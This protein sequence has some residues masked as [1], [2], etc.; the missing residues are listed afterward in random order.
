MVAPVH[1]ITSSEFRRAK[2]VT[3]AD[4]SR[5]LAEQQMVVYGYGQPGVPTGVWSEQLCRVLK[6]VHPDKELDPSG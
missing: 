2:C 3:A 4:V 6:Q 1:Q 5:G